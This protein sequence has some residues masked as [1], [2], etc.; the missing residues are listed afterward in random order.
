MSVTEGKL[1]LFLGDL[2]VVDLSSS[3][4]FRPVAYHI[5]SAADSVADISWSLDSSRLVNLTRMVL[6][7][8]SV[9]FM[10]R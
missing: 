1:M 9:I 10:L 8:L 5:N 3:A 4:G 2:L 6:S 7:P